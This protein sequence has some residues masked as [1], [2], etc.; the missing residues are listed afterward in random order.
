[1]HTAADLGRLAH[2]ADPAAL[3]A[4]DAFWAALTRGVIGSGLPWA[5]VDLFQD[6]L[7]VCGFESKLVVELA[8][9]GSANHRLL[10]VLVA[11]GAALH[12]TEDPALLQQE[13]AL[14]EQS[15]GLEALREVLEARDRSIA[16]R[17]D[18]VLAEGRIGLLF[19]GAAHDVA[20]WLPTDIA[21]DRPFGAPST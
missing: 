20:R 18:A 10:Q 21:V 19:V 17:I 4:G 3:R 5:Q 11:R 14:H 9:Q 15:A 12:G 7:P 2:R 1:M 8:R 13:V 6:G 16:A